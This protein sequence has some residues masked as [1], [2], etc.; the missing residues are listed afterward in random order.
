VLRIHT[1]DR[2]SPLADDLAELLAT[3]P[4]DPMTPEWIA[5][6]SKAMQRWL[7]LRLAKRLGS[8]SP[9]VI[10][11]GVAAN[12]KS[13]FPGS[14]LARVIEAD[15]AD[16]HPWEVERLAW[17]TLA[18]IEHHANDPLL[19]GLAD[20]G[21]GSRYAR[22]RRVADLFDRYNLHRPT[23]IRDWAEGLDT[24]GTGRP[25]ATHHRWQP[26][27]WR[28]VRGRMSV[29][30]PAER[31]PEI[32]DRLTSGAL[33][34]DL[35]Q[36]LV[37]FGLT[38]VPGGPGFMEL[39]LAVGI[40]H[41]LHLYLLEPSRAAAD[42]VRTDDRA[43]SDSPS[44]D[45]IDHP[46]LKS[47]GRP[48]ID[49]ARL[50]GLAERRFGVQL[51]AQ[52]VEVGGDAA[53]P[54]GTITPVDTTMLARL[55]SDIR[56]NV[57]PQPDRLPDPGDR[58]VQLHACYG[59]TR[60]VE[61]L[62]DSILRLLAS[63][64]TLS[65]DDII[66]LTPALERFAP[67]VEA[68]FGPSADDPE[69]AGPTTLRYRVA[70]RSLRSSNPILAATSQLL[71]MATG[72]F[73]AATVLDFLALT[74]VKTRFGFSADEIST[75]ATWIESTN[76]RWGLDPRHRERHGVPSSIDT[77]T[78]QSTVDRLLI[79]S[80]V[81]ADRPTLAL[82]AVAPEG[83]QGS[84]VE[85]AGRLA[86][87]IHSLSWLSAE[88]GSSKPISSWLALLLDTCRSLLAPPPGGRWQIEALERI[89][90]EISDTA[91]VSSDDPA[92]LLEFDDF[93]RVI[94]NR[95]DGRSG[96]PDFFRGGIT[97]SSLRPLRW[98]PHRV[99]CI[100]GLD[101][102]AF[103]RSFVDGDDLM[104]L[105]PMLGDFDAR[106]ENHQALLEA[107]LSA[108]DILMVFRDGHDIRTNAEIPPSTV[109]DELV[110]T[111]SAMVPADQRDGF[112]A[113]I[114]IKHPRQPFDE[115]C[116]IEGSLIDGVVAGF[117]PD[118]FRGAQARR[119]RLIGRGVD[120]GK[121]EHR[122]GSSLDGA[123]HDVSDGVIQ[124][125]DLHAFLRNP[126]RH[127]A[128]RCLQLKMP[129]S[130]EKLSSIL[131]IEP[132]GLDRW[133]FGDL[134]LEAAL[135]RADQ[136]VDESIR[137]A[138][139]VERRRGSIPPAGLGDRYEALVRSVVDEV[140][141]AAVALGVRRGPPDDH[142][143]D[144]ALD[145]GT[146]VVG[147]VHLGLD[148][149]A[150]GPA[151]VGYSTWKP[152]HLMEVWLDLMC[153]AVSEPTAD[154]RAVTI[155]PVDG[156]ESKGAE[157]WEI[158]PA[159]TV[160]NRRQRSSTAALEVVVDCLRRGSR[161]PIPLFPQ[162]SKGLYVVAH[163]ES[164]ISDPGNRTRRFDLSKAWYD[165]FTDRGD[166][167]DP[168]V[169]LFYGDLDFHELE[170]LAASAGDPPGVGGRAGRFAEY[171]WGAIDNSI[172]LAPPGGESQ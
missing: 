77:N 163:P 133:K 111:L 54:A 136:P 17:S 143:V 166:R 148:R 92:P 34:I 95:M 103:G 50:L 155:S 33:R 43:G 91:E 122:P 42:A 68:V 71:D 40:H 147:V 97:V 35:P 115:R 129:R 150:P 165:S 64:P 2:L 159:D 101:Q 6:P 75:I 41:D 164:R 116:F 8:S 69:A 134:M 132:N 117:D 25:L 22:A 142:P 10:H 56:A 53:T 144:I 3:A 98:L 108:D 83:I 1:S 135:S 79:G 20:P 152:R 39:A 26:H 84:D 105:A 60:Q 131:P 51:S 28:L 14:L 23:M 15:L 80:T 47:W 168:A 76:M 59:P 62:R 104:A 44:D 170:D 151:H 162:V 145:D 112:R 109:V 90:A 12:I 172:R 30:S 29:A 46:L 137:H 18:A 61:A 27:L 158:T 70:D 48:A 169:D 4:P 31:M 128:D 93:R 119:A 38:V 58:S 126:T 107:V 157:T 124:L 74:P 149:G 37:M 153:L 16:N 125:S 167:T 89:V 146:R 73:E 63:D 161:E 160:A 65:E 82:G 49:T 11:D 171:L 67:L 66:I 139:A 96:R 127:F 121:P 13:V 52:P 19:A 78:W 156:G 130:A 57:S 154:W 86:S 138:M 85:L 102:P 113:G 110:D 7:S 21:V 88:A 140:I 5:T 114:E 45:S 36:R 100:L 99:I 123:P 72:R 9:G 55:Q 141:D 120:A 81:V 118:A 94:G 32:L 24:D 106:G 87:V